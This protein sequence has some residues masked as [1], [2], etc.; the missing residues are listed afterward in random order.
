MTPTEQSAK[1]GFLSLTGP[2]RVPASRLKFP[3]PLVKL[4]LPPC[5]RFYLKM[6]TDQ[7]NLRFCELVFASGKKITYF[8]N[9]VKML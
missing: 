8:N 9:L 1:M 4:E 3:T 5:M 6:F 2:G 7:E